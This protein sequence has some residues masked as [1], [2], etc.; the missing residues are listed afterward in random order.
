MNILDYLEVSQTF[1]YRKPYLPNDAYKV[2]AALDNTLLINSIFFSSKSFYEILRSN[3]G[4][5][6]SPK[7]SQSLFKYK[8]RMSN[9]SVPFGLFSG[10]GIGKLVSEDKLDDKTDS[11]KLYFKLNFAFFKKIIPLAKELSSLILKQKYIVNDTLYEFNNTFRFTE[12][13][14]GT[15]TDSYNLCQLPKEPVLIDIVEFCKTEKSGSEIVDTLLKN[16]Y[17]EDSTEAIGFLK[18]LLDNN[19]LT[20][21]LDYHMLDN[22]FETTF[23]KKMTALGAVNDTL[24]QQIKY[25]QSLKNL[26]TNNIENSHLNKFIDQNIISKIGTKNEDVVNN[27][28]VNLFYNRRLFIKSEEITEAVKKSLLALVYFTGKSHSDQNLQFFI[29]KFSERYESQRIP[30]LEALDPDVGIGFAHFNSYSVTTTE[31]MPIEINT[32]NFE[33]Q[34]PNINNFFT[35][36]NNLNSKVIH[37]KWDDIPIYKNELKNI[38]KSVAICGEF[39]KS[40]DS[41]TPYFLVKFGGGTSA[42]NIIARFSADNNDVLELLK[43]IRQHENSKFSPEHMYAEISYLPRFINGSS[44]LNRPNLHEYE[45]PI[46]NK[47]SLNESRTIRLKDLFLHLSNKNELILTHRNGKRVIPR[48]TSSHDYSQHTNVI[49]YFLSSIQEPSDSTHKL[50]F[51]WENLNFN[52]FYPRIIVDNQI[53]LS[54]AKWVFSIKSKKNDKSW[55]DELFKI[56]EEFGIPDKVWYAKSFDN[57]LLLDF[58]YAPSIQLFQSECSNEHIVLEEYL[59]PLESPNSPA[60]NF[61]TECVFV[62][63]NKV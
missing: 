34:Q 59:E 5:K 6:F 24:N 3:Q 43:E 16:A 51:N 30:L 14:P 15:P 62:I 46:F 29:N 37:I 38:P 9:K 4:H 10:I 18:D 28:D 53:I 58:T 49:Y 56:K 42:A 35:T 20:G 57:K 12:R 61:N 13:I 31:L 25:F 40:D 63:Y 1:L 47:S 21:H 45:I 60:S 11:Y 26:G 32:E 8:L 23:I 27:L 52:N 41:H 17:A 39:Y 48:N 50:I 33:N 36:K 22:N 54:L 44:I 19:V 2:E 7:I 55:R